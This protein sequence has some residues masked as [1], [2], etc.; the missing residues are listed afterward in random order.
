MAVDLFDLA[1]QRAEIETGV[2]V[3]HIKAK[4]G[5]AIPMTGIERIKPKRSRKTTNWSAEEDQFVRDNLGWLS[6][7]EIAEHLGRTVI[8]VHMRWKRDLMLSAPSKNPEIFTANQAAEMIGLDSHKITYW[9]DMGFIPARILPGGRK[10]RAIKRVTFKRWVVNPENWIYFDWK[11]INDPHLRRLCELKA[12]RWGD[13][14]WSTARV[15][16]LHGVDTKDVQRLIYRGELPAKQIEL[17]KGGRHDNPSWK[18]WFVKRSDAVKAK[19]VRGKGNNKTYW[20]PS[21][22]AVAWMKKARRNRISWLGL[23]RSMGF[24]VTADTVK[25]FMVKNFGPNA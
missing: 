20:Q 1:I 3:R 5:I 12:K 17:S 24:V 15:A 2:D 4:S 7:E 14:W 22:R 11:K 9:C 16:K 19:F 25:N 23:A 18:L 13:E 6:E 21:R 8:A 10:I